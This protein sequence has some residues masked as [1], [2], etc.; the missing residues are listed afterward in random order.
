M[1]PQNLEM[2]M[3]LKCKRDLWDV[4]VF[5][6]IFDQNKDASSNDNK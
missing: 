4:K 1:L 2:I 6:T 5:A 3:F